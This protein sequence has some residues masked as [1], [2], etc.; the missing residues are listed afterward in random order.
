MGTYP[1][2]PMVLLRPMVLSPHAGTPMPPGLP[3]PTPVPSPIPGGHPP[4]PIP[5]PPHPEPRPPI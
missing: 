1:M 4:P 3:E 2:R 5:V